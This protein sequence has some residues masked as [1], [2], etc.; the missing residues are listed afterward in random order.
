[1]ARAARRW[2]GSARCRWL[3]R[4]RARRRRRRRR[5]TAATAGAV[6]PRCRAASRTANRSG[7]GSRAEPRPSCE[8]TSGTSSTMPSTLRMAEPTM[9]ASPMP[10]LRGSRPPHRARRAEQDAPRRP[11]TT[12]SRHPPAPT[13]KHGDHVLAG[14]HDRRHHGGQQR[15]E[16]AER[17]DAERRRASATWN[18]PNGWLLTRCTNGWA[19]QAIPMP[20]TA[21]T[22]APPGRARRRSPAPRGG[23]RAACRRSAAISAR[24]RS[25]RRAPTANA[26][27]A[28]RT[29]SSSAIATII[30][31]TA[32]CEV[33][34]ARARRPAW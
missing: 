6:R 34:R 1:M 15:T 24:E 30:A 5:P 13:G 19:S 18:G 22:T 28:S 7:S 12:G 9:V 4:C 27:P 16:Q 2:P 21:P 25:W 32:S 26:G 31:S 17:R 29:T 20:P 11:A 10:V 8:T 3:R 14:R 23:R 33:G